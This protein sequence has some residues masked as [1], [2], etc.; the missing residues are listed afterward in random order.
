MASTQSERQLGAVY[1]QPLMVQRSPQ[2]QESRRKTGECSQATMNKPCL[3]RPHQ[4]KKRLRR[5]ALAAV[6]HYVPVTFCVN[7]ARWLPRTH[8]PSVPHPRTLNESGA[9]F[10]FRS[11]TTKTGIVVAS[12]QRVTQPK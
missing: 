4:D 2:G 11:L 8:E 3:N 12:E 6:V 7:I 10:P 5:Q 9:R 1:F